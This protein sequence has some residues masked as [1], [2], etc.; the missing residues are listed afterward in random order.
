MAEN[1]EPQP[2]G[3]SFYRRTALLFG[4]ALAAL[5]AVSRLPG[6]WAQAVGYW[7]VTAAAMGMYGF[8]LVDSDR[9]TGRKKQMG[10]HIVLLLSSLAAV[11][12][13]WVAFLR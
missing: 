10:I 8:L 13:C 12:V 1:G 3:K 11:C 6:Q 2:R 5:A 9:K 4:A 7:I